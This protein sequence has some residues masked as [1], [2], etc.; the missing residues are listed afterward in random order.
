[1][2]GLC[3]HL[4]RA[5]ESSYIY[6]CMENTALFSPSNNSYSIYPAILCV[7]YGLCVRKI[8][9]HKYQSSGLEAP[10]RRCGH[11]RGMSLLVHRFTHKIAPYSRHFIPLPTGEGQGERLAFR[12]YLPLPLGI[13]TFSPR[14]SY[15]FVMRFLPFRHTISTLL[16]SLSYGFDYQR[17]ANHAMNNK[18]GHAP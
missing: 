6:Y 3:P 10:I 11:A 12:R 2:P 1:M 8:K 13:T 5:M 7:P 14:D 18:T 15:L 16:R 17:I 9:P 4:Q